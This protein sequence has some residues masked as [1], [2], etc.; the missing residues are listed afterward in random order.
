MKKL[1]LKPG[2]EAILALSIIVILGLPPV[3][4]AQ[5]E[6]EVQIKIENGD[7]T[8][9]GKKLKD[10]TAEERKYVLK[11][12]KK[13]TTSL[14]QTNDS[15]RKGHNRHYFIEKDQDS[16]NNK[17][18]TVE[19]TGKFNAEPKR[20]A[21]RQRFFQEMA[22][23]RGRKNSQYF[24]YENTDNDGIA[25]H[26]RF[27]VSDATSDDLKRMPY[28]EG[29]K[30]EIENLL[31]APEFSSGNTF[32][33]F[34][35]PLKTEAEVKLINGASKIIWSENASAG[36]FKKEFN[37]NLNGIYYLQVKQGNSFSV[38]RIIKEE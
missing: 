20:M 10:L 18:T 29:S 2:F 36:Q 19:I 13:I 15:V 32:I 7:T 16:L 27:Y 26:T 14:H 11:D 21:L 24:D 22:A 37:L 9:N 17:V 28:V 34:S 23:K 35:L 25:T 4:L 8:V 6:Q 31:I 38:K 12:I 3:L 30:F 1:I 33:M 5:N